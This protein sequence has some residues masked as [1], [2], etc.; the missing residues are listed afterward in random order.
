MK[1]KHLNIVIVLGAL[2]MALIL[3]SFILSVYKIPTNSMEPTF[4]PGDFIFASKVAYGF[5]LPFSKSVWFGSAPQKGDLVIFKFKGKPEITYVKR[6]TAIAHETIEMKDGTQQTVPEGEIFV[7][8]D[9]DSI[10]DENQEGFVSVPDIDGQAK[11]IWFSSTKDSGIR[12]QRI[13]S[14]PR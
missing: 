12:W 3:R 8:N 9:N 5:K 1:K 6:V 2:L 11:I 13:F 7:A 4:L 14:A 10:K